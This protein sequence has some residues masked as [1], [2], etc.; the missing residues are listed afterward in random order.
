[1]AG[2]HYKQRKTKSA[3]ALGGQCSWRQERIPM[4]LELNKKS[5]NEVRE[6]RAVE[7]T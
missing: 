6:M 5:E 1:M 2:E 3:T 4:W 7:E